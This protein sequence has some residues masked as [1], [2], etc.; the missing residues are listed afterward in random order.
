MSQSRR[1]FLQSVVG[2]STVVSMAPGLPAFLNRTAMAARST[3][4]TADTIL[5]V[6]QL[7]GGNDGLNT[8]V[9][10]DDDA[11]GRS[12]RTLR[13]TANQVHKIGSSLGFHPETKDFARLFKEGQLSVVQGVGYPNS[14]RSHPGAMRDW[15]T[16][17]PGETACQTGWLGRTLDLVE[18]PDE[19]DVPGV[20][21]GPT[22]KPFALN[23][24]RAIVPVIRT[25]RQWTLQPSPSRV[26]RPESSKDA[27]AK[28]NPLLAFVRRGTLAAH[29]GSR[30]VEAVLR[31]AKRTAEYPSFDFA[32]HLKTIA[33]LIR[34]DLGI[35]I[36]FTEPS[37]GGIGGFDNHANQRDNHAAVLRQVSASIAALVDDLKRDGLLNRVVLMTFSEFGRTL[38]ENGR[39]GTDHGAA[40]P[41]FLAGGKLKG[42]LLGRH[43][44]LTNL[45]GDAPK[46][47]TD[48]RRVYATVLDRWLGFNSH[49]ILGQKFEPLDVL[50]STVR[51]RS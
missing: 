3:P 15:H 10:Y 7:G 13:L 4:N 23:A 25:T 9:P 1:D 20:F 47:H 18:R 32:R 26:A 2:T 29:A 51:A 27:A 12:R 34:A 50:D 46:F 39:R 19:A 42:G 22:Q 8:V 16:A 30:Q 40:A 37:G 6:V 5:I 49:A 14:D 41:M 21:V 45:V 36:F 43:P 44:S 35:R 11:Y 28:D 48:F 38:T 31:D 17:R 33:E 24:Q